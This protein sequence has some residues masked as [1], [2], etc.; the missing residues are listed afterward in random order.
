[1]PHVRIHRRSPVTA[2]L[3]TS[4]L[5]ATAGCTDESAADDRPGAGGGEAA[6]ATAATPVEGSPG[7]PG[8]DDSL[9]PG[10][11]NGGYDALHYAL[12][13]TV[14]PDGE[15]VLAGTAT[16]TARATQDLSAFHLDLSGLEATK[17]T[18]DGRKAGHRHRGTELRIEPAE[19]LA[20]GREFEVAVTYSGDP[21][22]VRGAV[23]D[24][25]DGWLP[26]DDGALVMGEPVGAMTWYPVNNTVL[27]PATY[28]VSLTVPDGLTGVSNGHYE[29]REDAARDGFDTFRWR[30]AAQTIPYLVTV[31]VGDFALDTAETDSGVEVV[32]AVD[33]RQADEAREVLQDIPEF[34]AWG[35]EHF[36]PY[37]FETAGA[38]VDHQPEN[39]VALETLGRPATEGRW[40]SPRP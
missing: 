2:L 14:E 19:D 10:A 24:S 18:V 11:G 30:N 21:G 20:K 40:G 35:E 33:P 1:M 7:A 27:D 39:H 9:L 38:I 12:D 22:P 29:G 16:L 26:T 36:G 13:L 15:R 28:E 25:E 17:V 31:A 32:T 4:L 34:V 37:P 5:A 3:L 6:T 8:V 23:D